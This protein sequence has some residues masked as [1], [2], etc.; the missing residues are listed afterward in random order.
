MS[1]T[2][3]LSYYTALF[4]GKSVY[5]IIVLPCEEIY[6]YAFTPRVLIKL[7]RVLTKIVP[8]NPGQGINE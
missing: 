6:S 7:L 1:P 2:L 5:L 3:I 8:M 4:S